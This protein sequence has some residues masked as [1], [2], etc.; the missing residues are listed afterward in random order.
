MRQ[1]TFFKITLGV[2]A[3]V[4]S[5]MLAGRSQG[6]ALEHSFRTPGI[7]AA[8]L[9]LPNSPGAHPFGLSDSRFWFE[10]T[11]DTLCWIALFVAAYALIRKLARKPKHST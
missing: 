11:V 8:D 9:I 10:L 5:F 2:I 3:V 1:T 7:L 6:F 4:A